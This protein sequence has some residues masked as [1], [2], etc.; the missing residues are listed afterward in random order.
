[1]AESK[2]LLES[3]VGQA[4]VVEGSVYFTL[5]RLQYEYL[6]KE[7]FNGSLPNWL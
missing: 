3:G 7:V 1:M 2:L 4:F 6:N 5:N